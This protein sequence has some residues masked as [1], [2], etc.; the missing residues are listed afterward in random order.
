MLQFI[1]PGM[2]L[3][4]LW[5]MTVGKTELHK[6][7]R[8]NHKIMETFL[9]MSHFIWLCTPVATLKQRLNC[10]CSHFSSAAALSFG[11]IRDDQGSSARLHTAYVWFAPGGDFSKCWVSYVG[12]GRLDQPGWGW[13]GFLVKIWL[14]LHYNKN[15]ESFKKYIWTSH[16][17][18]CWEAAQG[19]SQI[20]RSFSLANFHHF[21]FPS[22]VT[23][24]FTVHQSIWTSGVFYWQ[25]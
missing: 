12:R 7:S 5:F 13:G 6:I 18:S 24:E 16:A 19:W 15:P 4:S 14:Y 2:G 20:A 9:F 22:D 11:A 10:W 3:F 23:S 8:H 25:R 21:P 17:V 1:L